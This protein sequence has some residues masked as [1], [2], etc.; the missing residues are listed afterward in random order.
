MTFAALD[1]LAAAALGWALCAPLGRIG[2][3]LAVLFG[4]G[5]FGAGKS[6]EV[7]LHV[8][9]AF[10]LLPAGLFLLWRSRTSIPLPPQSAEPFPPRAA[11]LLRLLC[12]AALALG[13]GIFVEHSIRWPDGDW[14]AWGNW[15]TRA[16][17]FYRGGAAEAFS[18]HLW[19]ADYPFLV[20][21]V[22]AHAWT[23]LGVETKAAPAAVAFLWA[24]L[25]VA[26]PAAAVSRLRGPTAGWL[27]AGLLVAT[28]WFVILA[29]NQYGD[30]PLA[31]YA[32]ASVALIS[33]S[34]D[35]EDR[36]PIFLAGLSAG[37][38]AFCKNEGLLVLCALAAVLVW[39]R[40]KPRDLPAFVAGAVPMLAVLA[41]HKALHPVG[42]DF[43]QGFTAAA[44][45]KPL[46]A[47]RWAII[48]DEVRLLLKDVREWGPM[49]LALPFAIALA[50][51]R[52]ALARFERLRGHPSPQPLPSQLAPEG[53]SA[54]TLCLL[55][56]LAY[57]GI[58]LVTP[59]DL[60]WHVH[61]SIDRLVGQLWPALA[62][63]LM[64]S[65]S[66]R[67]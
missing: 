47:G 18:P 38:G 33:L 32:V 31:A 61:G 48:G 25:A 6:V 65:L 58:Y 50:L 29:W 46:E 10:A 52:P 56:A 37:F 23:L 19:H 60:R 63:W 20:P 40:R 9:I 11:L 7:L 35:S 2:V 57:L 62:L 39:T 14:D 53:R 43:G 59:L 12:W 44:L 26:I 36:R 1:L 5:V 17:F 4:L 34:A 51:A 45:L 67:R 16:R 54:G 49:L 22:V 30:L 8:R 15:N 27:T 3:P 13:I 66:P 55:M 21:A 28:P 41:L 64:L 42:N 24:A